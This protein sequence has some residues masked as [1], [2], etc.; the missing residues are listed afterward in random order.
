MIGKKSKLIYYFIMIAFKVNYQTMNKLPQD[1]EIEIGEFLQLPMWVTLT[2]EQKDRVIANKSAPTDYYQ[3]SVKK[4]YG[5]P[6]LIV[7]RLFSKE[8]KAEYTL[9]LNTFKPTKNSPRQDN[10]PDS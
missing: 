9:N 2:K 1:V 7:I 3:I 6:L 10:L 4:F 5:T 8:Q